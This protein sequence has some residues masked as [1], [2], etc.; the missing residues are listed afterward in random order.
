MKTLES[1]DD[2]Q[3][4]VLAD[5]AAICERLA[6]NVTIPRLL[7][8]KSGQLLEEFNALTSSDG[9]LT[10]FQH[11]KA[12]ALLFRITRFLPDVLTVDGR[13]ESV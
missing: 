13:F 11:F 10:A 1:D 8:E 12:Q 4:I 7:R 9:E 6:E 3:L 2:L 5:L